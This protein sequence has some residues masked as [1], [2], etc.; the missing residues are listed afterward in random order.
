MKK[1][2]VLLIISLFALNNLKAQNNY[3]IYFPNNTDRNQKCQYFIQAFQQKPKEVTFGIKR[4]GDKLFFEIN[5]KKWFTQLFKNNGDGIAV[6]IV[7]KTRYACNQETILKQQVKGLLLKPIY[8]KQLRRNLKPS[9]NKRFRTLVGVI[10]K[11]LINNDL[12]FNILFLNNKSFCQYY[13]I[14]NLESYPWEL[15]DMGVYLDSLTYKSKKII[16]NKDKFKTRYKTLTFTVPFKKNKAEYSPVDIKPMYDSL[17]LTNFNIKTIKIKAYA[18]VEGSIKRNL[19]LQ[20]QRGN[21]IAKSLQSFQKPNIITEIST[22][23]NWVEFLNDIRNTSFDNLKNLS[24]KQ[25]KQKL[26]GSYLKQLEPYLK[27]HRK[28]VIILEL[29]KKDKYKEMS[30]SKLI[31][32]F[33]QSVLA[34]KIK[35]AQIIQNSIF[36]KIKDKV[37]PEAFKKMTIPKQKKYSTLLNKNSIYKYLLN[38]RM[39]LIVT[40]ELHQLEKLDPN[41]K[42]IKYNLMVIKF[43][44]W[45]NNALKESPKTFKTSIKNLKKHAISQDLIDRMM[46]NFH[47]IKAEK[48]MRKREYTK[49][50]ES[51]KF[52][53][54]SYKKFNLS[55]YD[56]LSLAQFLTYYSKTG[57]AQKLLDKK[58]RDVTIDENLLYYYLNLTLINPTLTKTSAYRTIMLNAI[59]LNKE[60]FCKLFDPSGK[61]GVTFQLL[62]DEYLRKTYC[63]NCSK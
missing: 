61:G 34:D 26:T 55:N 54:N 60:R 40:N 15:L 56:Y 35:E 52:I 1:I 22:S 29:Q 50:D 63:E 13:N 57:D 18:S 3:N 9:Q 6:D 48:N 62:E 31:T 2:A 36:D 7:S 24:K 33:N 28:A 58:V 45:R 8:A 51:V 49:K 59:N 41:N 23:E 12:E 5:N 43:F 25:V 10:P 37:S 27:N 20:K 16:S 38:L 21:S 42:N 11:A 53:L 46:V 47:I 44:L 30:I 4:E 32:L 39:A 14:Y 19:E 17:R